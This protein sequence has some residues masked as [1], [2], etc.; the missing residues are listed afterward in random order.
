MIL[1]LSLR[2]SVS[3]LALALLPLVA[4]TAHLPAHQQPQLDRRHNAGLLIPLTRHHK[5]SS[6]TRRLDARSPSDDDDDDGERVVDWGVLRRKALQLETRY[7]DPHNPG[8]QKRQAEFAKR[9]LNLNDLAAEQNREDEQLRKQLHDDEDNIAPVG[10][11]SNDGGVAAAK[12]RLAT[13]DTTSKNPS[14]SSSGSTA[15]LS[16]QNIYQNGMDL[17][18]LATVT[19]GTPGK[20]FHLIPDSGSSDTWLVSSGCTTNC[21]ASRT[22]YDAKA[23]TTETTLDRN[24]T[25]NYGVGKVSGGL[26]RDIVRFADANGDRSELRV[27]T[28]IGSTTSLSTDWATDAS[29][30]IMGLGFRRIA[31]KQ[32]VPIFGNLVRQGQLSQPVISF[33][34]GRHDSG[35]QDRSEMLVGGINHDRYTGDLQYYNLSKQGYWEIN[36]RGLSTGNAKNNASSTV[37]AI[38][39]TGTSLIALTP[40]LAADFWSN[41]PGAKLDSGKQYYT[42]PC[43]TKLNAY[44]EMQD[45]TKWKINDLDLNLGKDQKRSDQCVGGILVAETG[46]M[47]VLGLAFLKNVYTVLDHGSP[48]RVG[49]AAAKI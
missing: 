32:T 42:F 34:F 27:N 31:A 22:K 40:E 12:F 7:V 48:S 3:A 18:Y 1:H 11:D 28:T 41:V 4:R 35:T 33:A 20:T 2:L 44:L 5:Q 13:A 16:I 45:G 14:S 21:K 36:V 37:T 39:D 15:S 46:N 38:V 26:H 47:M 10:P 49:L 25:L 23:S 8:L 17:E 30:G 43:N 29:D 6:S 19:V 9:W 24:F